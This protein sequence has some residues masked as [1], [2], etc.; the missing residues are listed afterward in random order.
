MEKESLAGA[1]RKLKSPN[2]KTKKRALRLIHETK[3]KKSK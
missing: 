2:K 3:R 1:Y